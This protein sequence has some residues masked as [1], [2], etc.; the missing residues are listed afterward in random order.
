MASEARLIGTRMSGNAASSHICRA[1]R[2]IFSL[3]QRLRKSLI[4][5]LAM[6]NIIDFHTHAFPDTLADRAMAALLE[7][8]KKKWDVTAHLDGTVS[9]LLSSMDRNGIAKSVVCSIATRPSQFEPILAWS[10]SIRSERIIPF[11]SLHPDDPDARE[12]VSLIKREGFKGIKFHPYYQNFT[13]DEERLYPVYERICEE[14]LSVVMHT[15]FDLAFE[16]KRIADP[17]KIVHV[18]KR[19]PTFK[20]VT[21]HLGAWQDWDEVER[22]L[23]GKKIYMEISYA[24]DLLDA[25]RARRMILDHPAEYVL[26][27][28]DSPWTGQDNTLAMLRG[29]K[30]GPE[31]ERRILT[32]NAAALLNLS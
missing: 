3:C 12:K 28:S 20:L 9:S 29:L 21:T 1:I 6:R 23:V 16:R 22:L 31:R 14:G 25:E 27:G 8:G 32:D 30:L 10:R 24:L 13:I 2:L 17:A 26:F 7:E 5:S 15:G 11:P 4:L 18:M 19:F